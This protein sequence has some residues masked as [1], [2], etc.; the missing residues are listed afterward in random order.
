L[1]SCLQGQ[2][3]LEDKIVVL[4]KID[5]KKEN[6]SDAIGISKEEI[7]SCVAK[8]RAEHSTPRTL[9][10]K[11]GLMEDE[12][13]QAVDELIASDRFMMSKAI[14]TIWKKKSREQITLIEYVGTSMLIWT[15]INTLEEQGLLKKVSTPQD[16][17]KDY[18]IA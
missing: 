9:L 5:S 7:R 18:Y 6:T 14:A 2:K 12:I 8:I 3:N 13:S 11:L 16:R 4:D 1:V 10:E 15:M 17:G